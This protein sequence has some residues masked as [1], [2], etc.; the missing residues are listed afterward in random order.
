MTHIVLLVVLFGINALLLLLAVYILLGSWSGAPFVPTTKKNI[1]RMIALAAIHPGEICMDLGSGGG[2]IV[3]AAAN[4]GAESIGIE[5]NPFLYW[6]SSAR[7]KFGRYT[8]VFFFRK[9]LWTVDVSHVDVLTIFFIS[10]KMPRLQEKLR[11]E[12]KP[13]ARVVSHVFTFPDWPYEKKD[14]TVYIYRV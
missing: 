1:E 2:G 8:R 12:M 9:N 4:A 3:F 7:A 5:I 13:G 11:K 10:N 6:W 14:G